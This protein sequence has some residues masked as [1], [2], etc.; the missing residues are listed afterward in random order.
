MIWEVIA[1]IFVIFKWMSINNFTKCNGIIGFQQGV[2][3]IFGAV[4]W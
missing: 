3:Y 1:H 4:F 2:L